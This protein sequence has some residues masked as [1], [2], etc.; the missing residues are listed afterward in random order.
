MSNF[1]SKNLFI[2]VDFMKKLYQTRY[3]IKSMTLRELKA[4]YVGSLFG[5]MWE[6]INPLAQIAIFGIIFGLFF[7]SEPDP[8][9]DTDSF[10]IVLVCGLI[11]WQFFSQTVSSSTTALTSNK[12]LINKAV[13]FPS[14]ILPI[15]KVTSNIISHLIGIA[16]LL[17]ILVL[18]GIRIT[19][20]MPLIFI[21]LF[22]ISVLAVGM[23]WIL[24]SLN[25]YLK[26]VEQIVGVII[27]GWFFFTPI[28]YSRSMVPEAILPIFRLNPAYHLVVGYRYALL[29]GRMLP[30]QGFLYLAGIS[31]FVFAL[32]GLI[33]RKLKPGF[34]EVL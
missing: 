6:V 32:G 10:F 26:D 24:S 11:P 16:L 5:L 28:V 12:N 9:Y 25:V 1:I 13:G 29:A 21:Y 14:E 17:L 22:F 18:F 33:F 27:M 7:R 4:R 34:A 8:I 20:F 19:P 15:I 23:G 3:M 30:W 31:F 2:F